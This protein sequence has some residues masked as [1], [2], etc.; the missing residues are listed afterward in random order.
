MSDEINIHVQ[1]GLSKNVDVTVYKFDLIR[2]LDLQLELPPRKFIYFKGQIISIDF[3]FGYFGIDDGDT[4]KVVP[5]FDNSKK[6]I[7]FLKKTETLTPP[8]PALIR[9]DKSVDLEN[10][11]IAKVRD[12]FFSKIEGTVVCHRRL[13]QRFAER[14]S[15]VEK[16]VANDSS[17]IPPS[18]KE[19]S[20]T[21]LPVFWNDQL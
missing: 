2:S 16:A 11:Q 9:S 21:S 6:R 18:L 1:I 8:P 3:S 5:L 15:M 20:S 19:P 4:L 14:W 7:P 13:V 10:A 12:Q 17:V